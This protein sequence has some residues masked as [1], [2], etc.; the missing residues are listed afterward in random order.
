M[1]RRGCGGTSWSGPSNST[2]KT[3]CCVRLSTTTKSKCDISRNRCSPGKSTSPLSGSNTSARRI[4]GQTR[5]A[6]PRRTRSSTSSVL[7]SIPPTSGLI[8]MTVIYVAWSSIGLLASP[9]RRR[10]S[11]SGRACC[12]SRANF[13]VAASTA[14]LL[15]TCSTMMAYAA[16]APP[17]GIQ[18][19][20][21]GAAGTRSQTGCAH[22][23]CGH[24]GPGRRCRMGQ[25]AL[26]P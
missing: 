14:W 6:V 9:P 26:E 18:H 1:S 12:Y 22:A 13:A 4:L 7:R 20:A 2:A 23:F 3:G 15:S 10:S 16:D 19:D 11:G 5:N 17:L 8:L 24:F 21:S 25:C